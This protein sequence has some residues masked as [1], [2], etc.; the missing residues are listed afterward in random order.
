MAESLKDKLLNIDFFKQ[1]SKDLKTVYPPLNKNKFYKDCIKPL[2]SLELKQRVSHTTLTVAKHLPDNYKQAISVLYDLSDVIDGEFGYLFMSEF[3]S[4]Y[5][6][7]NY[8]TSMNALRDF[9]H[10]CSSEFA[11]RDFLKLDFDKSIK[12]MQEWAE[13][14]NHHIRRLASEGSRPRLP[15]GIKLQDV[16]D[17]PNLTWAILNKLKN[18]PE[19]YVQKS[20]ANH[21]NDISKDNADWLIQKLQK[22]PDKAI[23]QWI[24]KHGCRTLIKK[25]HQPTLELLGF[26]K[27]Y[28][29][30][31]NLN[32]KNTQ[33]TIG[34]SLAFSFNINNKTKNQQDLVIDYNIHFLKK[35]GKTQA[36]TFKLK[37]MTLDKATS[38]DINKKHKLKLMTTRKLY[39]GE[40]ILEIQINGICFSQQK[41]VLKT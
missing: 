29:E 13:D 18:D 36:K 37:T 32:I 16:I 35:S 41:F 39:S 23:T 8:K 11:I 1:L 17:K 25:G 28:I 4:T 2:E 33:I 38:V 40:H 15:W 22:W 19:K 20:V 6:L 3:V 34:E 12:H 26:S 24:I 27:P 5:G 30:V 14:D 10:H 31:E 9:T 21:L 7:D